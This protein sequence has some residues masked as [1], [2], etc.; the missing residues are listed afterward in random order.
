MSKSQMASED[1]S[2]AAFSLISR[3]DQLKEFI[4]SISVLV[5]E[6]KIHVDEAGLKSKAVDPA[7]VGMAAAELDADA[8]ESYEPHGEVIG[9]NLDR[10][11]DVLGMVEKDDLIEMYLDTETR[12]LHMNCEGLSYT[13]ALINPDSIRQEPDI[14]DL[15]LTAEVVVDGKEIGRA[16]KAADM[17]SDHILFGVDTDSEEFVVEATGDTDDVH[18]ELGREDLIDLTVGEAESLFSLDYMKDVK[19]PI[20]TDDEVTLELG[21]EFPVKMHIDRGDLDLTYM[22]APRIESE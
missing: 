13:L 4:D 9:V 7:N 19:K 16:V 18:F 15:D 21:E 10:I 1:A 5:D 3:A 11:T 14:P 17:V 6:A 8:F 12:K 2:E 22:V 20:Q